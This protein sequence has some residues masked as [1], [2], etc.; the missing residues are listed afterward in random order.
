MQRGKVHILFLFF[1]IICLYFILFIL[2]FASGEGPV[3]FVHPRNYVPAFVFLS[4]DEHW[5]MIII[6]KLWKTLKVYFSSF[7]VSC[8]L[9]IHPRSNFC[10][11]S[12]ERFWR[13]VVLFHFGV[14]VVWFPHPESTQAANN[15]C[16]SVR[17]QERRVIHYS[18]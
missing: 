10:I 13:E 17:S 18:L 12:I 4:Q 5:N 6:R 3:P 14:I 11:Q 15:S 1:Q 16:S 9:Q 7:P 8:F 2:F